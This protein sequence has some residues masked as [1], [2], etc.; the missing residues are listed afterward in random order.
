MS[1]PDD[2]NL[3]GARVG[4]I[5]RPLPQVVQPR[6]MTMR[7]EGQR[8]TLRA[9]PESWTVEAQCWDE[10]THLPHA[11]YDKDNLSPEEADLLCAGCP[12]LAQCLASALQYEGDVGAHYRYGVRGGMN[13]FQ[14]AEMA[15]G[16]PKEEEVA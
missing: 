14:R 7:S 13:R 5:T 10:E 12:A 2:Y 6:G 3:P 1:G 11:A 4:T 16:K 15:Q 9:K 8:H